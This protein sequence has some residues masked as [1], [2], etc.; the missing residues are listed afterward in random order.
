MAS[1]L[2][3][4]IV[5]LLLVVALDHAAVLNPLIESEGTVCKVAEGVVS[6]DKVD[7]FK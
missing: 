4:K 5:S 2:V 6:T 7:V 3:P 1:L